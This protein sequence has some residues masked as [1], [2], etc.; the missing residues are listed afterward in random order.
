VMILAGLALVAGLGYCILTVTRRRR[1]SNPVSLHMI[2]ALL[3]VM[4]GVQMMNGWLG[5]NFRTDFTLTSFIHWHAMV[6]APSPFWVILYLFSAL[7]AHFLIYATGQLVAE[8]RG[9]YVTRSTI[10]FY[11]SGI[12]VMA[13]TIMMTWFLWRA[14]YATIRKTGE[15]EAVISD[16][17][18]ERYL[19][20]WLKEA[21]DSPHAQQLYRRFKGE[22]PLPY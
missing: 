11:A 12:T 16:A 7:T 22:Y 18:T 15:K 6:F 19:K 8:I 21:P 2:G 1:I 10:L 3:A 9:G 13:A 20:D 4:V 14:P 17:L 5:M